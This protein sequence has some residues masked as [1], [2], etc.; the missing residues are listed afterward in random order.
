M[1]TVNWR[2]ARETCKTWGDGEQMKVACLLLRRSF[3]GLY[4]GA[5]LGLLLQTMT[6]LHRILTFLLVGYYI[7]VGTNIRKN[8][9]TSRVDKCFRKVKC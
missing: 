9:S 1:S 3:E 2:E 7:V 4:T 8:E 6:I 5:K